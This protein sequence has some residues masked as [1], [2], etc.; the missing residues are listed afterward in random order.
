METQI[1]NEDVVKQIQD[2]KIQIKEEIT[3]RE[4]AN[5]IRVYDD[6]VE[7]RKTNLFAGSICHV[8]DCN[9][10]VQYVI[11]I[12]NYKFTTLLCAKHAQEIFKLK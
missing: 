10:M 5:I 1:L 4:F 3:I 8:F 6:S 9:E 7:I 2:K 12:S 11:N